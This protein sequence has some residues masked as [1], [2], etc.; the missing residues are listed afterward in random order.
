MPS[1]HYKLIESSSRKEEDGKEGIMAT[2]CP[3]CEEQISATSTRTAGGGGIY[4][5]IC[6]Q[7]KY[8]LS[9]QGTNAHHNKCAAESINDMN[10]LHVDHQSEQLFRNTT[11]FLSFNTRNTT[12]D[13]SSTSSSKNR[14]SLYHE[15]YRSNTSNQFDNLCQ[16]I[17]SKNKKLMNKKDVVMISIAASPIKTV[18]GLKEIDKNTSPIRRKANKK[19]IEKEKEEKDFEQTM[20][21]KT[22]QTKFLIFPYPHQRKK[23]NTPYRP[24]EYAIPDHLVN[25]MTAENFHGIPEVII[26]SGVFR[27]FY[28]NE[29]VDT[30]VEYNGDDQD[31]LHDFQQYFPYGAIVSSVDYAVNQLNMFGCSYRFKLRRE[32]TSIRCC[33]QLSCRFKVNFVHIFLVETQRFITKEKYVKGLDNHPIMI[34]KA[35]LNHN[36]PI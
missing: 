8:C 19:I 15:L 21:T 4:F 26:N 35:N 24:L 6:C 10:R 11:S 33:K 9:C 22:M 31:F 2:S 28:E 16:E 18:R 25:Y 3:S 34:T 23:S 36:H 29:W 27:K 32:S 1:I 13:Y 5:S 12:T 14:K 7:K 17:H 30:S 20:Q